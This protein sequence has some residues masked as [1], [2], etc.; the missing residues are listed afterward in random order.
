MNLTLNSAFNLSVF[1]MLL[2]QDSLQRIPY[3]GFLTEDSLQRI[4]YRG[5]LTEDSFYRGFLLQRIP[6]TEARNNRNK[7]LALIFTESLR[8]F[9]T[10]NFQSA[11]TNFSG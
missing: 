6:F 4:P 7:K 1:L 10:N 8:C 9:A 2:R 5:F 11:T 3:R